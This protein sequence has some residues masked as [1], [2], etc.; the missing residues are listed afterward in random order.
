MSER[1]MLSVVA[2]NT[3]ENIVEMETAKLYKKKKL[4]H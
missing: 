2:Q 3:F 1:K 4:L